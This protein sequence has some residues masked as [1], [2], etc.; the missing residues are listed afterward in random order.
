MNH[1]NTEQK[2]FMFKTRRSL[3][4]ELDEIDAQFE[5]GKDDQDY[6]SNVEIQAPDGIVITVNWDEEE[7]FR[8]DNEI[9]DDELDYEDEDD[10]D[11]T[12]TIYPLIL[13]V[14]LKR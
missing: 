2:C 6:E 11:E 8:A 14:R 7:Q 1:T 10:D 9:N 4:D 13:T 12:D 5:K 3:A